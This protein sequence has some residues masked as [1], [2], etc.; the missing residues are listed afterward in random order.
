M[1][2]DSLNRCKPVA[3]VRVAPP[4]NQQRLSTE[5]A[6][7]TSAMARRIF[8]PKAGSVRASASIMRCM[9]SW[10]R[11]IEFWDPQVE[12]LMHGLPVQ[13]CSSSIRAFRR[14]QQQ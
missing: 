5:L 11:A 2:T 13:K 12:Y 10:I 14:Q 9:R 4:S 6:T 8:F 1:S 7:A 3:L